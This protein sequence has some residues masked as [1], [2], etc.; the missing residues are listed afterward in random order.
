VAS[1]SVHSPS[2]PG[3]YLTSRSPPTAVAPP[4]D[5][6]SPTPPPGLPQTRGSAPSPGTS[7]PSVPPQD[8][9]S[10]SEIPPTAPNA[11]P[12]SMTP[13]LA[14]PS[15]GPEERAPATSASS[16]APS[17]AAASVSDSANE[18][19]LAVDIQKL[20]DNITAR[21]G[22][23]T[24][25]KASPPSAAAQTLPTTSTVPQ[26]SPAPL[27]L[28]HPPSLPP[29]PSLPNPPAN[30]PAIS[31]FHPGGPHAPAA[32]VRITSPG[33]HGSYVAGEGI[34]SLPPPPPAAYGAPPHSHSHHTPQS[35]DGA[36]A[37]YHAMPIK[38]RWEQFQTDEKRY[39]SE[40]KWERF[41][42]GS[43]IF[44]GKSHHDPCFAARG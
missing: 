6:R 3:P 28:S 21:A 41:P 35:T 40:A 37:N 7:A 33:A 43:R 11:G 17:P 1:Q 2:A 22:V 15:E 36:S 32:P 26:A 44:I 5:H 34:A 25:P 39:T 27:I 19:G 18:R 12:S 4:A 24:S 14:A 42:E 38:Q 8:A 13:A 30:L 10:G 20:V 9:E 29:K 16:A 23:T 31:Q